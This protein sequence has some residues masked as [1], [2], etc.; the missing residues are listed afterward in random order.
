MEIDTGDV[1]TATNNKGWLFY[2]YLFLFY[3]I[4]HKY[5]IILPNLIKRENISKLS[6]FKDYTLLCKVQQPLT[7][8]RARIERNGKKRERESTLKPYYILNNM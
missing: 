7:F 3:Q 5:F 6:T 1:K 4:I 2:F 8:A